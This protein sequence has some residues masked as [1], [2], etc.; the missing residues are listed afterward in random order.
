M[1]FSVDH[2]SRRQRKELARSEETGPAALDALGRHSERLAL[3]VAQNPSAPGDLLTELAN[4]WGYEVRRSVASHPGTPVQ[5]LLALAEYFPSCVLTNPVLEALPMEAPGLFMDATAGQ[6]IA[7]L[8]S[9]EAPEYLWDVPAMM[10]EEQREN[11]AK[12]ETAPARLLALLAADSAPGVREMVAGNPATP[13][14]VLFELANDP[15]AYVWAAVKKNPSTSSGLYRE[16]KLA[17]DDETDISV[18][19][20]LAG[21]ATVAVRH[22]VAGNPRLPRWAVE[23][24]ARDPS[25]EVRLEIA[26]RKDLTAEILAILA[27]GTEHSPM[28]DNYPPLVLDSIFLP[29]IV[30]EW[31]LGEAP[32]CQ[33][34]ARNRNTSAHVLRRMSK[35]RSAI[36]RDAIASNEATPADVLRDLATDP[37][38]DVRASVARNAATPTSILIT[39][40]SDQS[41]EVRI[42]VAENAQNSEKCLELLA[43]DPDEEVRRCLARNPAAPAGILSLLA[44][45]PNEQIRR[46]VAGNPSAPA[47]VL[48]S[49][50]NDAFAIVRKDIAGNPGTPVNTLERLAQDENPLIR[51]TASDAL[52][53]R[54]KPAKRKV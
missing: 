15:E 19:G 10:T 6:M 9:P 51:S 13:G 37:Y 54:G 49:L 44:K 24:L 46:R 21:H 4:E 5:T 23:Q 50:A 16:L 11:M 48:K 39:L 38:K 41:P 34:V 31:T 43:R 7:L 3:L 1:E 28:E 29:S 42:S 26:S 25:P 22:H 33:A 8:Q 18:L 12:S 2:L 30:N 20:V 27:D 47:R 53:R 17:R 36:L 35:S 45:D 52:S 14:D 40:A 32:I